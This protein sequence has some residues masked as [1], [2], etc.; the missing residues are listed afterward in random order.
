MNIKEG[1]HRDIKNGRGKT[2]IKEERRK[3]GGKRAGDPRQIS[4]NK[5]ER[6][7]PMLSQSE[8]VRLRLKYC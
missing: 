1:T 2:Y 5:S 4:T 6:D 7:Q 3:I 8:L